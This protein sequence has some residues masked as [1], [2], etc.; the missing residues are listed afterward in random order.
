MRLL[1]ASS[2][3]HPYSKSGGLADMVA[4]L[5]KALGRS[6][7]QVGLVTPLYRGIRERYPELERF[8]YRIDLPLGPR[9]LQAEVWSLQPGK[10]VTVYFIHQPEFYDRTAL[11]GEGDCD[12]PDNAA[13]FIFFSKCVT[14]LARYLTWQPELVHVH[15]WQAG[16]VPLLILHQHS[17]E[18]WNSPPRTCLTI[19]NLAYQGNFPPSAYGLTNLPTDY[20]H[21][22]GVEFWGQMSCLKAGIRYADLLTTVSPRYAREI[23]TPEFGCGL[24]SVLRERHDAFVGILNGVDYDEWNT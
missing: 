5:A 10:R 22:G 15:D 2:E 6:G 11:Y 24:D 13:R 23:T 7:H 19:H 8:D 12:Y 3:V 9:H 21:P 16:L 20:F 1:L 18:G 17:R 14:H 4:A